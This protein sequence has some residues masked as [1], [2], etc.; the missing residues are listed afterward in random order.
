MLCYRDMT[1]CG[2]DC[3]NDECHRYFGKKEQQRSKI[4]WKDCEGEPPVALS[5]FSDTCEWYQS[6]GKSDG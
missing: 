4:W 1:F 2:S 3:T 5:D 6:P